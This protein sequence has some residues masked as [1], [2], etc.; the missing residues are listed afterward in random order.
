MHINPDQIA[1]ALHDAPAW[2]LIGLT[3]PREGL[4]EDAARCVAD[5]LCDALARPERPPEG[6][7][8]LPL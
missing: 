2:T 8:F 4:R 6:Q 7:L 5:H 3:A 1:H